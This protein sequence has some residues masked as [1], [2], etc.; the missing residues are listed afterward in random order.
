MDE[1]FPDGSH[2]VDTLNAQTKAGSGQGGGSFWAW[3]S[4]AQPGPACSARQEGWKEQLRGQPLCS[5]GNLVLARVP[6]LASL[7]EL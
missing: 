7:S 5:M 2:L 6:M 1:S 4:L 3:V